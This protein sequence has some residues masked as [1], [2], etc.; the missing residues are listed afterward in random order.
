M[1]TPSKIMRRVWRPDNVSKAV[2]ECTAHMLVSNGNASD[3]FTVASI[4]VEDVTEAYIRACEEFDMAK[5]MGFEDESVWPTVAMVS[6]LRNL[7]NEVG[8]PSDPYV[9]PVHDMLIDQYM[10]EASRQRTTVKVV[11]YRMD[12]ERQRDHGM[13]C[14]YLPKDDIDIL[15]SVV[16][17]ITV[18]VVYDAEKERPTFE[19]VPEG[20]FA[21][22]KEVLEAIKRT[23]SAP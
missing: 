12:L 23:T 11:A 7:G 19:V 21:E 4:A 15:L 6:M 14:L 5:A 16:G 22:D 1:S 9:T 13:D 2:P 8:I 3:V 10:Q 17:T 18:S 20:I